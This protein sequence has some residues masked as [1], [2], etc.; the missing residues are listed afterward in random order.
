MET[1]SVNSVMCGQAHPSDCTD[2]RCL[3]IVFENSFG[4][5]FVYTTVVGGVPVVLSKGFV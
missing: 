3:I 1:S 4:A 2:P 5:C